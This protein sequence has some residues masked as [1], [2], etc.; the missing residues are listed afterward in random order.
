MTLDRLVRAGYE[1]VCLLTTVPQEIG[2]T[3]GHGE[4][5]ELIRAQAEALSL[6]LEFIACTFETYTDDYISALQ[7]FKD[8]YGLEA[9]AFG[10]LFLEEHKE[11]GTGVAEAVGVEAL[12]PLWMKPDGTRDALKTF[13]DSGFKAV[14]IRVSDRALSEEWLGRE[15]DQAFYDDIVRERQVCPMGEGGEYH[16]FVYDGPLFKHPVSFEKGEIL[17]LETTK[18]LELALYP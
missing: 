12:Y 7:G 2:R 5:L 11:W 14:V 18:R 13:V 16:T 9:I 17:Q 4:K 8:Q 3:F 15:V 10:D 6:P 1:V